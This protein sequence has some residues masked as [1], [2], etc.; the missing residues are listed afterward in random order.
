MMGLLELC[1]FAAVFKYASASTEVC[2][3][4]FLPGAKGNMRLLECVFVLLEIKQIMFV[5]S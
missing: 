2:T 4:T 1:V 3:N 5:T